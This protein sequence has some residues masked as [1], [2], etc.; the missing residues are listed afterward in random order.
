MPISWC[1]Q[2]QKVLVLSSREAENI[3]G[4]TT[5]CQAVWLAW[6]LT[7]MTRVEAG[8]S[9]L[10][11]DNM[12][13]IALSKNQVFHDR[14]KCIDTKFHFIHQCLK[15]GKTRLDYANTNDLLVDILTKSLVHIK[16]QELRR[17]IGIVELR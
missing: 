1:S 3:A 5:V 10:K 4:A 15:S 14:S 6:L 13:A 8:P 11:I 17:R 9:N 2:K 16:F 7:E 12:S